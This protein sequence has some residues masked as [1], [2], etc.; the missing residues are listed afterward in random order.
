MVRYKLR[1]R[2]ASAREHS[3]TFGRLVDAERRK[4]EIEVALGAGTWH[5]PRRGDVRLRVSVAMKKSPL[6]AR[7][8]S[9]LVAS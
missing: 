4:A 9:P 3:E 1:Y 7:W 2:D 8:W 6:V 5:D